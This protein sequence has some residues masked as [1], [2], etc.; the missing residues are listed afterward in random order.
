MKN[1]KTTFFI[2]LGISAALQSCRMDDS[3]EFQ[4]TNALEKSS[5][6]SQMGSEYVNKDVNDTI[7]LNYL[8]F[9]GDSLR[10]P[11][12]LGKHIRP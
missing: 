6:R 5:Y 12:D 2:L 1:L 4:S 10:F 3:E 9:E 7:N 11:K 8:D